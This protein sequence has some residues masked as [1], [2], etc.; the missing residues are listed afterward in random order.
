MVSGRSQTSPVE[1]AI[2]EKKHTI[3]V[4]DATIG[5]RQPVVPVTLDLQSAGKGKPMAI[6]SYAQNYE[7]V[8]LNRLFSDCP[9]GFYIDVGACHPVVHSVTKLFY[10]RGW[11]GINV[12]PIPGLCEMLAHDRQRDINLGIGLS[13]TARG[14]PRSSS[15]PSRWNSSTFSE[16]RAGRLPAASRL[17]NSWNIRYPS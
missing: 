7:D 15:V 8:L 11:H 9:N 5:D 6:I 10:E 1:F 12:E 4:P 3:P 16:E 13:G 17:R 2:L 14:R